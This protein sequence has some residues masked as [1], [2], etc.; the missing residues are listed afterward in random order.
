MDLS[1]SGRPSA[2]SLAQVN[3]TIA[4]F[5][6]FEAPTQL[7]VGS[8][9]LLVRSTIPDLRSR[10]KPEVGEF[11]LARHS[12]IVWSR[13]PGTPRPCPAPIGSHEQA[14][15]TLYGDRPG[16]HDQLP[17]RPNFRANA[18]Q[19]VLVRKSARMCMTRWSLCSMALSTH[20]A[21]SSILGWARQYE[22]HAIGAP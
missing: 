19:C 12:C 16:I 4:R 10:D 13:A 8:W 17:G 1:P 22:A 7:A 3:R 21:A 5:C 6:Q 2:R 20:S 15:A 9:P 14:S 18:G 11:A